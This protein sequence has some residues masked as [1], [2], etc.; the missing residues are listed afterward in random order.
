MGANP[1]DMGCAAT[2]NNVDAPSDIGLEEASAHNIRHAPL[3]AEPA[4]Y[5]LL[6]R[7]AHPPCLASS[8]V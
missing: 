5:L 1:S 3:L 2:S 6:C 7:V 8:R 4:V